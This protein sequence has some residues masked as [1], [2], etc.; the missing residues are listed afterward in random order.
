[1]LF[2]GCPLAAVVF[3][4]EGSAEGASE[5]SLVGVIGSVGF[6]AGEEGG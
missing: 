3:L 6:G 4:G 2:S 5:D 1:V